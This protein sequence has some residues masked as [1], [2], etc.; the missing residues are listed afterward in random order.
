VSQVQ[1]RIRELNLAHA[2]ELDRALSAQ[3]VTPTSALTVTRLRICAAQRAAY[4]PVPFASFSDDLGTGRESALLVSEWLESDPPVKEVQA[5]VGAPG[6]TLQPLS[7]YSYRRKPDQRSRLWVS[8]ERRRCAPSLLHA[9]GQHGVNRKA[10]D[11]M[12]A[13]IDG[14]DLKIQASETERLV[15]ADLSRDVD[16]R[17]AALELAVGMLK[18]NFSGAGRP[19][20]EIAIAAGGP[21]KGSTKEL[22]AAFDTFLRDHPQSLPKGVRKSLIDVGGLTAPKRRGRGITDRLKRAIS[23]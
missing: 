4:P 11:H 15:T 22:R 8:A 13:K 12:R 6:M 3:A 14:K 18:S 1:V 19:A 9:I 10:V 16:A 17:R 5:A 7:D 23:G 20:A 2:G 21:G